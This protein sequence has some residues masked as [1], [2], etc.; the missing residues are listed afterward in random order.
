MRYLTWQLNWND[1]QHGTG[2]EA[3]IVHQGCG[4]SA[5][6]WVQPNVTSGTILGYLTAGDPDLSQ[7]MDWQVQELTQGEALE[8]AQGIDPE[9][10]LL[11]D[12]V[13]A[14]PMD[15]GA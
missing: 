15:E 14:A 2:P 11:D 5:S 8:F 4:V 7:L 3:A 6:S 12:G 13:I 9:A 1:P 10:Y